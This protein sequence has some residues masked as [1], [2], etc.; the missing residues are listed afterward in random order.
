MVPSSCWLE[1]SFQVLGETVMIMLATAPSLNTIIIIIIAAY[2]HDG[3]Y[4]HN[5]KHYIHHVP[6]SVLNTCIYDL[7]KI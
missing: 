4:L 6:G 7:T 2:I 1:L 5:D 3:I